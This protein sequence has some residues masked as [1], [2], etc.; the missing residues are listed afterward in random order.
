MR[1]F[2]IRMWIT[3]AYQQV[4]L[5]NLENELILKILVLILRFFKKN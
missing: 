2:L 3:M 5:T 4:L 1:F